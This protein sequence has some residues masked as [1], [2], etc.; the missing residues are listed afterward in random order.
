MS[1]PTRQTLKPATSLVTFY[2]DTEQ[3]F[4]IEV[5]PQQCREVTAEFL[6]IERKYGIKTTY[7]VVGKIYE[8][9]PELIA[10]IER[11]GHEV[12]F[13]S[14]AHK[15]AP[16]NYPNEIALCRKLS[17]LVKGY[18][19]PRSQ[20]NQAALDALWHNNFLWSAENGGT[21]EPYF[22]HSGLVRLPIAGDDWS[23]HAGQISLEGW[24]RAFA[25]L[26]GKGNCFGFGNHDSVVSLRP[27]ERLEA[28][29][30]L[31]KLA[32]QHG[33]L[34]VTFSQ[35]ADLF[36]R[37]ALS[38][39]YSDTARNWNL[40]NK[41]LYRTRKFMELIRAEAEKRGRQLTVAD[42]GSA[43]GLL[44]SQ[45][46]DIAKT[47]YC[48]DNAYGMLDTLR[49][50]N[51]MKAHI[52]DV[53]DS[54]LPD[55]SIDLVIAARVVE[56]LFWPQK[57]TN[58][59]KRIGKL[60]AS[61]VLTCPATRRT[62]PAAGPDPP[63]KIRR[64]FSAE[65]VHDLAKQIGP[66]SLIGIYESEEAEA[67]SQSEPGRHEVFNWVYIGEIRDKSG[68]NQSVTAESI[69]LD[70]FDFQFRNY[71]VDSYFKAAGRYVP[72]PVRKM[73]RKFPYF[74]GL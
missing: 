25:D 45:L 14:Y 46:A 35:A 51:V 12:A 18:R 39:F 15:Y 53:T 34:I 56:Y 60:G 57:L 24:A 69:P 37:A 9:Q 48:V 68:W 7:N 31:I 19:S 63:D 49:A 42:L 43:G 44:T 11:D 41:S 27:A 65:E 1:T 33:A 73:I 4:G 67:R 3:N 2:H 64:Y 17:T 21:R 13:H 55:S 6:R 74:N 29:E 72:R 36:R 30:T 54:R 38:K 10:Q 70:A 58:E 47:V 20:W 23:V 59:I 8:E 50:S 52:G 61:Y 62:T 40:I 28:Y 26:L 66:G 16:D 71:R 22:I 5:S 32:I